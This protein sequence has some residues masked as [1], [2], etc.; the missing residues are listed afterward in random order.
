MGAGDGT[1]LGTTKI[2][3][4]GSP[5]ERWNLVLVGDG[6]RADQMAQYETDAQNFVDTLFATSPFSRTL[7]ECGP[8][9]SRA[10]N[11]YR[12]D[13]T[14]TDSGADDPAACGGTGAAPATF[15][16]AAFCNGG[17]RRLL[18]VNTATVLGVVNAQVPQ[19]HMIMVLVN[20]PI[21]GGSGGAMAVFSM[22]PEAPEIGLHEMGHTAFGFAD[23]Y[24]YYAG[25][26]VD[27]GH[28][29]YLGAEP[30]EPNVTANSNGNTIKWKDLVLPGTAVPTTAN[31]DCTQCDPQP[32]PVPSGT[33]GAF[34]GGRYFHCG[35]YRPEF[36]CRMRALGFPFCAVC[37][38]RIVQTL[39][40]HL[41]L[42]SL[43]DILGCLDLRI[44]ERLDRLIDRIDWV[45][46][47]SPIDRVRLGRVLEGRRDPA[48]RAAGDGLTE[49]LARVD[50]MNPAE[51][52]SALLRVKTGIARL[53]AAARVVEAELTARGR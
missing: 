50:S 44:F 21:Y 9:L 43:L 33:V 13:V 12:V 27:V 42:P 37:E 41:P 6:Y 52:R 17:I 51:L 38:R 46:D 30:A 16:D 2:V 24:E 3:D 31:A 48:E 15:F 7:A 8:R 36:D 28:D 35:V 5:A 53:E 11:V 19:W 26:G 40:P 22:A 23:E 25:C 39:E 20:S 29:Q 49:L 10:I 34:E 32:S 14:S 4:H 45:V 1:V 18:I 47:P